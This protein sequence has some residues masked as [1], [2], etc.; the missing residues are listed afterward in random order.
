MKQFLIT[1]A[2]LIAVA[3]LGWGAHSLYKKDGEKDGDDKTPDSATPPIVPLPPAPPPPTPTVSGPTSPVGGLYNIDS[4]A[5]LLAID[6]RKKDLIA[7]GFSETIVNSLNPTAAIFAGVEYFAPFLLQNVSFSTGAAGAEKM[8][9]LLSTA[10]KN[11]VRALADLKYVGSGYWQQLGTL[12]QACVNVRAQT[13]V[14]LLMEDMYNTG[15]LNPIRNNA[16]WQYAG[17]KSG[18]DTGQNTKGS[19]RMY[20]DYNSFAKN[21]LSLAKK[22]EESLTETAIQELRATGW[23]FVGYDAPN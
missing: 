22:A 6:K 9:Y 7:A 12:V 18:T 1:I 13:G 8:P 20:G 2:V 16:I 17:V 15:N 10:Q 4:G 14:S 21:W 3:L 19:E 23:K 11:A 5:G